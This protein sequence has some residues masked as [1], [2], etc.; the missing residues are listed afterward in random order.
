MIF[1]IIVIAACMLFPCAFAQQYS[2]GPRYTGEEVLD[3]LL[4][5]KKSLVIKV[6]SGGCTNKS[7]YRIV[8]KKVNGLSPRV[9]HYVLTIN[10]VAIDECKAI[11]EDGPVIY[12]D[13]EKELGLKGNYTISVQN[14]VYVVPPAYSIEGAGNSMLSAVKKHVKM[15][16]AKLSEETPKSEKSGKK[17]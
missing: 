7:S 3:E 9:P 10:R 16:G 14:M 6:G 5:G 12:W 4:I 15:E 13:L 11:V 8:A 1:R 17:P 2:Q